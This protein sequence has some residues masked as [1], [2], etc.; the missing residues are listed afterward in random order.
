M[1]DLSVSL[2]ISIPC[3]VRLKWL[4]NV[5]SSK[6]IDSWT[7]SAGIR[8]GQYTELTLTDAARDIALI[9]DL[10]GLLYIEAASLSSALDKVNK[11]VEVREEKHSLKDT[12]AYLR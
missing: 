11:L 8:E 7:D 2:H 3:P 1:S 10:K 5:T 12:V 4:L 9:L 6:L